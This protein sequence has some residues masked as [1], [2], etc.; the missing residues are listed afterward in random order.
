MAKVAIGDFLSH[1]LPY[2]YFGSIGFMSNRTG[3]PFADLV[4]SDSASRWFC[5][6]SDDFVQFGTIVPESSASLLFRFL[7]LVLRS[8]FD[9]RKC[10]W[11]F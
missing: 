6:L 9:Y 7:L 4:R 1:L 11:Q 5:D 8:L 10:G 3:V 2:C